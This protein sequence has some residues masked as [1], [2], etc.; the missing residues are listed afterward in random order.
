MISPLLGQVAF[1]IAVFV[2]ICAL[3]VLPFVERGS[4]EFVAAVLAAIAGILGIV[5][6][7][8]MVRVQRH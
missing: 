4:A 8:I 6:I 1:S 5:F 3:G 7:A 2:L